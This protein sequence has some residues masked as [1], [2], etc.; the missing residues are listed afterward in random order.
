M[1][2][3]MYYVLYLFCLEMDMKYVDFTIFGSSYILNTG[4]AA[5]SKYKNRTFKC[6]AWTRLS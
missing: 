3:V 1:H 5:N 6:A 2:N 4:E